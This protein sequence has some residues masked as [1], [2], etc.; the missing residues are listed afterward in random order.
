MENNG[1]SIYQ[2]ISY[3]FGYVQIIV[4]LVGL[5]GNS[6]II[7]VFSRKSLRKYSYS[8]YCMMMAISDICLMSYVFIEWTA[9]SIGADLRKVGPL[10]CKIV[11]FIPRFFGGV[12]IFI[13]TAITIDRMLTIVYPRRFLVIKKRWF[14]A[15]IV[16]ILALYV[17]LTVIILPFKSNLIEISPT[18]SSPPI[19]ICLIP[20]EIEIIQMW[21]I[22]PHY[23]I[24]NIIINNWLNIKTVRFI[25][26]SRRRVVNLNRNSNSIFSARDRKFTLCSVCL[27]ISSMTLKMPFYISIVIV[28]YS[29][30]SYEEISLLLKITGIINYID[31]GFSFFINM[32]VNSLF[33]NE[34]LR[35]FR[36]RKTQTSGIVSGNIN[37]SLNLKSATQN[38]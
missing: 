19:R 25:M 37:S 23:V 31:N 24:L 1:N 16:A 34:F 29:N 33:Y 12:S 28:S 7:V 2:K 30:L 8:F 32:L 22:L 17:L 5:V 10:I 26:A 36:L 20:K 38:R 27:N 35:L 18:N 4:G 3:A 15:L 13:L 21:I 14:Q 6:L 11:I 9:N